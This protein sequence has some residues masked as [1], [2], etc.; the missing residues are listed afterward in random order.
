MTHDDHPAAPDFR[1]DLDRH[2]AVLVCTHFFDDGQPL[3]RV[4][5]DSDG[6]WQFLCGADHSQCSAEEAKMVCL[7]HVVAREPSVNG[8]AG[9]CTSHS[10]TRASPAAEWEIEDETLGNIRRVIAE[11]G[12]WVGMIPG[13]DD[14]PGFAYTVGLWETLK[15]P[16]IIILGLKLQSMH[17]ILNGCGDLIRKG[18]RFE[19][20]VQAADVVSGYD[21]RFR[22]LAAAD[23]ARY[24]GYGCRHYGGDWF[25][26]VQC[27]WPDK[28]GRFP[29]DEGV[30]DF[31]ASAQPLL[32]G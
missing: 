19:D 24:L 11:F 1:F 28:S 9:M 20:G 21:V 26:A 7:E 32:G 2:T 31:M 29:G 13:D 5:H 6:D 10:A 16:E 3:V 23:Y 18:A 15:H 25:P 12:W 27:V 22:R 30:A 4:S 17:G 14:A 8:L